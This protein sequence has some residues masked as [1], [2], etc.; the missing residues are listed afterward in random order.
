MK[1]RPP[2]V[3]LRGTA[4]TCDIYVKRP[5]QDRAKRFRRALPDAHSLHE[6]QVQ[7]QEI[8]TA[9][10]AL[11]EEPCA[12]L[13]G[14]LTFQRLVDEVW[15]PH[16]VHE[17]SPATARR[18]EQILRLHLLP[19]FG[20][21]LLSD[22]GVLDIKMFKRKLR[23]RELAASTVNHI[24][25]LL[26][27]ILSDAKDWRMIDSNP[28]GAKEFMRTT[29]RIKPR[30]WTAE[31]CLA[32]LAAVREERP[33]WYPLFL[34]ALL[35]GLRTGEL[36]ALKW[37]DIDFAGRTINVK[38]AFSAGKE[39]C[40]KPDREFDMPIPDELVE[41]LLEHRS[42]AGRR[43]RVFTANDGSV[44]TSNNM[45]STFKTCTKS[46]GVR[47]I[48]FHDQRRTFA[49][50]LLV[51]GAQIEVISKLLNHSDI[52]VTQRYLQNYEDLKRGAIER[53]PSLTGQ[54]EA[55]DSRAQA[56]ASRPPDTPRST[57]KDEE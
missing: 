11:M 46:A 57:P 26:R 29:A 25:A 56:S 36:A 8:R 31:E 38:R 9:V 17:L 16:V 53:R 21:K 1:R 34:T 3:Y 49:E 39:K 14:P 20:H 7:A 42:R 4:W 15:S 44:L 32:F 41:V 30:G 2:R 33:R 18:Y 55:G 10:E 23:E 5:G 54:A 52:G 35:T 50:Q 27:K 48:R 28:V 40:T 12:D 6:A 43:V 19:R 51:S 22:I 45:K 37:T 13:M 24:L 47:K